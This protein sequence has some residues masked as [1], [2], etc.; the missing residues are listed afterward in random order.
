[1]ASERERKN[2]RMIVIQLLF[3]PRA[4]TE[5]AQALGGQRE[6]E[7]EILIEHN[8]VWQLVDKVLLFLR[9]LTPRFA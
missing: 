4:Q 3:H 2:S 1:M 7:R 6:R 5:K 8:V 9:S